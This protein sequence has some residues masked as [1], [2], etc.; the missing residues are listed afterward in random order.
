M[1]RLRAG[2]LVKKLK[3]AALK[4]VVAESCSGGLVTA[5]ITKVPGAS[6]ALWGSFVTYTNDAKH[7]M[8][9]V[10]CE[11]LERYGAVSAETARFMLENALATSQADIGVS[12]TGLAGPCGD[13]SANPVGLVWIAAGR[14]GGAPPLVTRFH[15]TG[16]RTGIR[17]KTVKAALDMLE[18]LA[19]QP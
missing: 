18:K 1:R 15:F 3:A 4:A 2:S 9:G 5:E 8:L 6:E 13:G 12:I 10:P 7:R 16:T 11:T 19:S 14:R 17:L